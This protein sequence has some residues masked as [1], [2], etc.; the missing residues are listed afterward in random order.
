MFDYQA[1]KLMHRHS[2]HEWAPMTEETPHS[3][4][5]HDPER[6]LLRNRVFR[7]N[8]CDEVVS[9]EVAGSA[10]GQGSSSRG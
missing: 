8:T 7:C 4:A 5:D 3:A 6:E 2:D 1:M 9:I 10:G